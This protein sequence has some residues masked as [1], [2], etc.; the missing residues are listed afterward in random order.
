LDAYLLDWANLL[1]RWTHLVTGIAW[2]GAS[3]YFVWLDNHLTPP[4]KAADRA[5]GAL[6]ELW[7]V[8]G[9]GFYHNEKFLTGP[10]GEPLT[11]SLH[12]FKWEAYSTWLSGMALLALV[13]WFG[14]TTYLIDRSVLDWSPAAAIVASAAF[15]ALGWV[16]YDAL[17][18]LLAKSDLALLAAVFAYV[19]F[20]SWL[21][22]QLFSARAACLHVGA[23]MG[24]VMVANVFF[25]IIPGQHRMVAEIRA[26]REPDTTPG[27]RGKQ[28]STHN[29]YFTLPVLFAMI[30]NHYPTTYASRYGWLTLVAVMLAGVLVRIWFVQRHKGRGNVALPV[31]ATAVLAVLAFALAP[32]LP[33]PQLANAAGG[34]SFER[35]H[36]IMKTR[37]ATCHAASPTQPGFAQP[38]KGVLLETPEQ[39]GQ[40]VAK[41][42]ETVASRY[43][44]IGNLT[45]MTDEERAVVAAW[46]AAG[47]RTN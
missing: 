30:S 12:W 1:A 13:Y 39:I 36:A 44:P 3:F 32:T 38:P 43:M 37:C 17:C 11:E 28:R 35:V 14:A 33:S 40:H 4:A 15:L 19:V 46:Y 34:P 21:A 16:V 5:R 10:K 25:V 26:G 20:A 47:A 45:G 22:F 18:R 31:A 29:T 23:M 8:H 2:I 24:T 6:G 9:G 42:Q 7:S 41:V 27:V